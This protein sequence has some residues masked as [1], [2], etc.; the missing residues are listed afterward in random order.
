MTD[1]YR[2]SILTFS[3]KD[4]AKL[5][6]TILDS[7]IILVM[8]EGSIRVSIH[9]FNNGADVDRLIG[10]LDRFSRDAN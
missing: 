9:L 2:S 10:V 1:K 4:I 3:G 5:H 6:R 8:R 7:K